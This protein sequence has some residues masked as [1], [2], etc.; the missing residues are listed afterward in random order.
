MHLIEVNGQETAA[1]ELCKTDRH[2]DVAVPGRPV[3]VR[4]P[5]YRLVLPDYAIEFIE[6]PD[7]PTPGRLKL[8]HIRTVEYQRERVSRDTVEGFSVAVPNEELQIHFVWDNGETLR[9]V[10][11][12]GDYGRQPDTGKRQKDSITQIS[13]R[14]KAT[15]KWET[16]WY[17]NDAFSIAGRKQFGRC[18]AY[19]HSQGAIDEEHSLRLEDICEHVHKKKSG[20]LTQFCGAGDTPSHRLYRK[21]VGHNGNK[22]YWLTI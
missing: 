19:M 21:I 18:L 12:G 17:D 4:K 13:S 16:V 14:V 6:P 20:K 7:L 22:R 15:A 2:S 11:S 1:I 10:S 8:E 3:C 9:Y 5:I